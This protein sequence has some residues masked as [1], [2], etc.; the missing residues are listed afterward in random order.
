MGGLRRGLLRLRRGS[1]VPVGACSLAPA[2]LFLEGMVV[3]CPRR[4]LYLVGQVPCAQRGSL[5]VLLSEHLTNKSVRSTGLLT[6]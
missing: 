3:A 5:R 4:S 1:H 2:W 6:Y